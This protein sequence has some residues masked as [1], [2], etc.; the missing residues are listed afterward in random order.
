MYPYEEVTSRCIAAKL[1][2]EVEEP[3]DY[4]SWCRT[5]HAWSNP[6]EKFETDPQTLEVLKEDLQDQSN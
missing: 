1:I 6:N 2:G 3:G 4:W 5:R